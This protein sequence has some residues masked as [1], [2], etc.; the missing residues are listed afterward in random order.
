MPSVARAGLGQIE[1]PR[2][3]SRFPTW[4]ADAQAREPSSAGS[5]NAH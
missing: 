1:E 4:V 5:H 2:T 3:S